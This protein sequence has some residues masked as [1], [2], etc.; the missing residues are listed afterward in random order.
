M[1][2]SLGFYQTDCE[3]ILS[4]LKHQEKLLILKRRWL[5]GL[6]VS[7]SGQKMILDNRSLPES[8]LREDDTFSETVRAYVEEA[9]G[10]CN[11]GIMDN[12]TQETDLLIDQSNIRRILLSSMDALTNKGLYLVAK[13][14]TRGSINFA[15][16]RTKMKKIIKECI[17]KCLGVQSHDPAQIKIFAELSRLLNNPA[18]IIENRISTFQSHQAAAVKILDGLESLPTETLLAM[19]RRLRGIPAR[20]PHL[21]WQRCGLTREKLINKVRRASQKMLS[22]LGKGDK[23]QTPLA[24][25]LALVG[26][27]LKLTPGCSNS[28]VLDFDQFSPKIKP[29]QDEIAKALWFLT[30]RVRLSELKTLQL[31]LEPDANIPNKRLRTAMKKMLR[32]YLFECND[33]DVIPKCLSEVLAII[34][35]SSQSTPS[36]C[37]P[38]ENIQAE[39]ECIL[40]VSAQT[41]QIVWDWIPDYEIDEDFA[42]AYMEKSEECVDDD[43]LDCDIEDVVITSA[44][45]LKLDQSNF[46][47]T[48]SCSIDGDCLKEGIGEYVPANPASPTS[49]AEKRCSSPLQ[50]TSLNCMHG[51]D[52]D[53]SEVESIGKCG[54]S[55]IKENCVCI[56]PENGRLNGNSI[57]RNEPECGDESNSESTCNNLYLA[58][59]EICDETSVV[60]YNII[61][62]IM[63]GLAREEG[64][65]IDQRDRSYLRV[66]YTSQEDQEEN[67]TYEGS[68]ASPVVHIVEKLVPSISKSGMEKLTKLMGI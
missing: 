50:E 36:G 57:R 66:D 16:T 25:A 42:D 9:F 6:P 49:M 63:E 4:H 22:E 31:L 14:L 33:L 47:G 17:A 44:Y 13:L 24:K 62:W 11:I 8:L 5:M 56:F 28:S 30:T 7:K 38:R 67:Q 35:Q 55:A 40:S 53:H 12:L 39:V 27:S 68:L 59:Q 15:K 51:D 19:R 23:L 37:F 54:A 48:A 20:I 41:K 2:R 43:D 26:L 1:E 21:R 60:V 34:N 32:E 3:S 29:L 46:Q 61:G 45:G 52:V 10:G 58:I 64:V 65:N 18:N